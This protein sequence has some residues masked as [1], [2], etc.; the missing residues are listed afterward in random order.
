MG[1]EG[2]EARSSAATVRPPARTYSLLGV[3]G[4]SDWACKEAVWLV[5]DS[6]S[7]KI[8]QIRANEN[9]IMLWA[10]SRLKW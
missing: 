8:K 1:P 10:P 9:L 3:E 6:T 7:S 2:V 5:D 4:S